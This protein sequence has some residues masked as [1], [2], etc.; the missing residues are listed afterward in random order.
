MLRRGG[1]DRAHRRTALAQP[2]DQIEALIGRDPARDDQQ[3]APVVQQV[4][5]PPRFAASVCYPSVTRARAIAVGRSLG[6]NEVAA[7]SWLSDSEHPGDAARPMEREAR[8]ASRRW[9]GAASA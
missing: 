4:D 8:G 7:L 2:A 9:V 6:V 1:H 5:P 3:D